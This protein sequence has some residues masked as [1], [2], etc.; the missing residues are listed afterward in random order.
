MKNILL[1]TFVQKWYKIHIR[2]GLD[3][4]KNFLDPQHWLEVIPETGTKPTVHHRRS[5]E[6][7]EGLEGL[8]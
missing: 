5:R 6:T 4:D 8:A 1:V 7:G 2:Q 3:S